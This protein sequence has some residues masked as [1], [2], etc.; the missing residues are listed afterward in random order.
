ML[1]EPSKS[2]GKEE[3]IH[4][5]VNYFFKQTSRKCSLNFH[6]TTT[7]LLSQC[8]TLF[9]HLFDL[10][11]SPVQS[12]SF[13]V[14]MN[15]EKITTKTNVSLYCLYVKCFYVALSWNKLKITLPWV[16]NWELKVVKF[17]SCLL[18]KWVQIFCILRKKER[19]KKFAKKT[20]H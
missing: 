15:D 19:E 20:R 4:F 5:Y 6:T 8:K 14:S 11:N 12:R 1:R 3:K 16:Q 10:I 2:R 7:Q 17:L 13:S 9:F 18:I